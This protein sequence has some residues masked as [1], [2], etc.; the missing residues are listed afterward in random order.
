MSSGTDW[1]EVIPE[2]T[3][4]SELSSSDDWL[5]FVLDR[6][7]RNSPGERFVYNSGGSNL[8]AAIVEQAT[9]QDLLEFART[10]LFEPIGIQTADW[11][12]D[13]Q[14]HYLGGGDCA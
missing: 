11:S 13:P 3:I 8:L 5:Q 7:M 4:L 6:P 10:N 9:G 1:P 2:R 14:G 12:K